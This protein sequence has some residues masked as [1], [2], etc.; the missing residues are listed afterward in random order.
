MGWGQIIYYAVVLIISLVSMYMLAKKVGGEAAK[1]GTLEDFNIATAQDRPIQYIGGTVKLDAPNVLWYGALRTVPIRKKAGKKKQTVGYKYFLGVQAGLCYGADV[2]LRKLWFG[3]D[4]AWSGE[5]SS[6]SFEVDKKQLFGGEDRG[7]G[8]AGTI[9]FYPGDRVQEEDPYLVSKVGG[10]KTSALRGLCYLVFKDFY[11]GNSTSLNSPAMELQR[12][13]KSPAGNTQWERIGDDANPAYLIYEFLTNR[14]FGASMPVALIDIDAIES[15]AERLF[16]EGIGLS[17]LLDSQS[18]VGDVISDILKHIDGNRI[19][20][21][22]TGQLRISLVRPD[23]DIDSLP[24]INESIIKSVSDFKRGSVTSAVSEIR[25]KYKS[26]SAD[27]EERVAQAQNLGL[28]IHK[29]LVDSSQQDFPYATTATVAQ[30]IAARLM[31]P[32]SS[33]LTNCN[34]ECNRKLHRVQVGDPIVL[35]WSPLDVTRMVMR[36]TSVDLGTLDKGTIKLGLIQDVF[37]TTATIYTPPAND[38]WVRPTSVAN[39][40]EKSLIME[41][42]AFLED[43]GQPG[44]L[45]CVAERPDDELGYRLLTR[46]PGEEEFSWD[47]TTGFSVSGVIVAKNSEG[48]EISGKDL[49]MLGNATTGQIIR[50]ENIAYIENADLALSEWFGYRSVEMLENGNV[51]ISGLERGL[52]DTIAVDHA[53]GARVWFVDQAPITSSIAYTSGSVQAKL[54]TYTNNDA[55]TEEGSGTLTVSVTGR[56]KLPVVPGRVM[57]NGWLAGNDISASSTYRIRWSRRSSDYPGIVFESDPLDIAQAGVTYNVYVRQDGVNKV[58][59]YGVLGNEQDID[60]TL[61]LPGEIEVLIEAVAD[62][63]NSIVTRSS[64]FTITP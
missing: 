62:V 34:V 52:I 44:H 51:F 10:D 21:A 11:F 18:Q 5:I 63:G 45:I 29:G 8:V 48:F 31:I 42:P 9:T 58:T 33:P 22:T 60:G 14:M 16:N 32:L 57:L 27:Y 50:G 30:G 55:M 20:D 7:G 38:D 54:L 64:K 17:I 4:L 49:D 35:N 41:C 1:A 6:G 2:V 28:R 15:C 26:R 19:T 61:F 39:P 40:V 53:L 46:L 37:G 25:V 23:Y 47:G 36:V 13:P 59:R 24:V 43:D 3:K 12:F 56:Y